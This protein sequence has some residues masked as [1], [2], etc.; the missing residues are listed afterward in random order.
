MPTEWAREAWKSLCKLTSSTSTSRL[1]QSTE[2]TLLELM[3]PLLAFP[4]LFEK[5]KL[6]PKFMRWNLKAKELNCMRTSLR[7]ER[8]KISWGKN[9]GVKGIGKVLK[10]WAVTRF[11]IRSG[12]PLLIGIWV[13]NSSL[14]RV[15]FRA[16][17]SSKLLFPL[18]FLC[19]SSVFAKPD[20]SF[21]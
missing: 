4:H 1:T 15:W 17:L 13:C 19:F 18:P 6:I 16:A 11:L 14:K 10:G 9:K 12:I 8:V 20:S 21:F 5:K 7:R 3:S 2:L